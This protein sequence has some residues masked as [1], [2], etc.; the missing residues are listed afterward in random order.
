MD[1]TLTEEQDM[2]R[3]VAA[4]VASEI[5]PST[6][7]DLDVLADDAGWTLLA[8]AGLLGLRV[9]AD[10]GGGGASAVEAMIVAEALARRLCP[11]PYLGTALALDILVAAGANDD[12]VAA[13]AGGERRLTL[14]L[15]ETLCDL[16]TIDRLDR[17]VAW[18]AAGAE[19]ALVLDRSRGLVVVG[20][21]DDP[22]D[23]VDLTREVRHLAPSHQCRL[24]DL[25]GPVADNDLRR[26]RALGLA[27]L[28]ADHVGAM[29][30]TLATAV[31]YSQGRV[32]FDTTIA[33]FQAVQHLCA[34][35]YVLVEGARSATWYA[36]WAVEHRPAD[37][38]LLA[39]RT[40]KAFVGESGTTVAETSIQVHGGVA[41]TWEYLPH[42]FL[43]RIFFDRASLGDEDIQFD[44]IASQRLGG[45]A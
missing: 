15:D 17:A 33:S 24:G 31:G 38:A 7:H 9:P 45:A 13:V 12:L 28:A 16:A 30:G 11:V 39:A 37:L 14:A 10:R 41:I 35:S 5:G 26:L 44:A 18:D 3:E 42:V 40:A 21:A 32:Q 25:G 27:L 4:G 8:D 36:A 34:E 2:L 22:I 20:V 29:E 1:V 19:P 6:P 43:R 23:G